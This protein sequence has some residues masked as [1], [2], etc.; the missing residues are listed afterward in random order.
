MR[1]RLKVFLQTIIVLSISIGLAGY[2]LISISFKS[3]L[4]AEIEKV[5]S[6]YQY[7]KFSIQ[8][9]SMAGG[10]W[11][12]PNQLLASILNSNEEANNK[13][14]V[15]DN[16]GKTIY[17]EFPIGY[18]FLTKDEISA[19]DLVYKIEKNDNNYIAVMYGNFETPNGEKFLVVSTDITEVI[20]QKNNMEKSFIL[21]YLAGIFL[22]M[23][24]S[25]LFSALITKPL[26]LLKKQ[27]LYIGEGNYQ[28][29]VLIK[30]NDE[31]SELAESFNNMTDSLEDKINKI[32][33]ASKQKEE[34][35]ANFAH[36]L[37]TPLT[38]IIGYADMIYQ[39][40][41]SPEE[42]KSSSSYILNEGLRLESL[43]FKLMDLITLN[44]QK[45]TLEEL[46]ST[47]VFSDIAET[48]KPEME[49]RN[50]KLTVNV[51]N[52]YIK[53]EFDLFKTLILNLIDNA[54]K[55]GS[56]EITIKGVCEDNKFIITVAD[57]GCGMTEEQLSKITEAFYMVDKA[58]SRAHH[59][60]GLGLSLAEKIAE[61]HGS[62]L[63]FESEVSVGT[64]VS[65]KLE[66]EEVQEYE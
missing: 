57:N 65:L 52:A 41:L 46:K 39:R 31:I 43:S 55:A 19:E 25:F 4:N 47:E 48:I 49:K 22:G 27:A 6:N 3:S 44:K 14:A 59:S 56:T 2:L 18:N 13:I 64:K 63:S 62:D 61:V 17:S 54:R 37:K 45:F 34:F 20:T 35:V 7:V 29:R 5:R 9:M 26:E 58:R 10:D 38:S 23:V 30:T 53:I 12:N 51:A 8:S 66:Y 1:L 33:L 50:I 15:I 11:N 24:L 42:I 16:E 28:E 32:E 40:K 60:A 21:I 36:E